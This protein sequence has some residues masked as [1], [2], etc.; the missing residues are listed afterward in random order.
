MSRLLSCFVAPLL[1]ACNQP[2]TTPKSTFAPQHMPHVRLEPI[3]Q[4]WDGQMYHTTG[5]TS[6]APA[7]CIIAPPHL[8]E[9]AQSLCSE[10]FYRLA[11]EVRENVSH[12]LI[13]AIFTL[14][15]TH[16]KQDSQVKPPRPAV[17]A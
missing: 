2:R 6:K 7:S 1:I 10:A 4:H 13:E 17:E 11:T 5:N 16:C 9:A 15:S 12:L 14:Q 3:F 8:S